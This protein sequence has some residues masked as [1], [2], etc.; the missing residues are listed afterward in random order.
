[1]LCLSVF[2]AGCDSSNKT[3]ADTTDTEDVSETGKATEPDSSADTEEPIDEE[4]PFDGDD[5]AANDPGFREAVINEP[6]FAEYLFSA[7]F[8]SG[9]TCLFFC[10][11]MNGEGNAFSVF[12][13][14]D[15][16]KTL[17]KVSVTVPGDRP[18]DII[19]A[20]AIPSSE[21]GLLDVYVEIT[22]EGTYEKSVLLYTAEAK[23]DEV[24]FTDRG[25]SQVEPFWNATHPEIVMTIDGARV[26]PWTE[27]LY[28]FFRG[29][30]ADGRGMFE[31]AP[32]KSIVNELPT[33]VMKE[34]MSITVNGEA[35]ETVRI[36]DFDT[37]TMREEHYEVASLKQKL[38]P[39]KYILSFGA[40]GE[41]GIGTYRNDEIYDDVYCILVVE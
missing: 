8:P 27:L 9:K 13:T 10:S 17:K 41:K 35:K 30:V 6:G 39:G 25:R 38:G 2:F 1:M 16:G 22:A 11:N 4:T 21:S 18:H 5:F 3:E 15:R 37:M 7:V 33:F 31:S 28:A 19:P 23:G 12:F 14:S 26:E 32:R 40:R 36:S 20:C 34:N 29:R 24:V